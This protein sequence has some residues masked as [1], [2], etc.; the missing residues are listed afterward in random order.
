M[1]ILYL[2]MPAYNEQDNIENTVRTWYP[3]VERHNGDGKSRLVVFNDG[4]KDNTLAVCR[5][6]MKELPLFEVVDKPN[7][8][9]GPT[10]IRAYDYAIKAGA[11]YIFQT[12]SDG[13]TNP[14]EVVCGKQSSFPHFPQGFQHFQ[15]EKPL[16]AVENKGGN[17][18]FRNIRLQK[19]QVFH[20]ILQV[21]N[22]WR[23]TPCKGCAKLG[24]TVE[25]PFPP[26]KVVPV[27]LD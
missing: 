15:R 2:V 5:K 20:K 19:G 1:D 14:D 17:S 24:K 10:V 27:T 22:F 7:S 4:S 26:R 9:H 25:N 21:F 18:S 3:I 23:K 16:Y 11:D 13:Q 8:G 12:D 6:L